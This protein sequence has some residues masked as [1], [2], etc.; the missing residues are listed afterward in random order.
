MLS[1]R[2]YHVGVAAEAFAAGY[3]AQAGCDV[4]VQYGAN[5]PE[6]DLV[7]S[8]GGV[9]RHVSVKGS[10][11]GGWGLIQ[12]Y[13]SRDATYHEAADRWAG[14]HK[15]ADLL[16]CFVQFKGVDLGCCPRLY[17][18]TVPEVVQRH[19]ESRNGLGS[20]IL[21][22]NYCYAKGVAKGCTDQLPETWQFTH[23]RLNT[24][25]PVT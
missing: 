20:T 24:F 1:I 13:K 5:Q 11:D 3:F 4:L 12:R 9:A 8:R 23:A 2:P 16:Y 25:L 18:A 14:A 15:L 19:K 7:V 10:Q 6:Y 21:Y 22:E 17:L